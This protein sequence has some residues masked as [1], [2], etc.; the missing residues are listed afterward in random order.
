MQQHRTT[1][2]SVVSSVLVRRAGGVTDSTT[3]ASDTPA[4]SPIAYVQG[5]RGPP[6]SSPQVQEEQ[7]K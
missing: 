2:L 3:S 5:E 1:V 7:T 4:S 6:T